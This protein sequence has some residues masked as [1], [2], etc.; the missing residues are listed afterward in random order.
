AHPDVFNI[1]LQIF[2]DGRLTDS[3]GHTVSFKNTIIIMTSNIGSSLL[4]EGIGL[5]GHI[6]EETRDQVMA[7]L[8]SSFRPEFLNRLDD[9][10]LFKPLTEDEIGGIVEL[11]LDDL[12]GRLAARDISLK[13]SEAVKTHIVDEGFDPVYG[14]RPLKRFIQHHFETQLARRLIDG[15]VS[16]GDTVRADLENGALRFQ[17]LEK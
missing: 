16:D 15:T 12:R 3:Q 2:D 9:T 4:L 13:V 6:T 10:V 11:L 5:Q 1:L 17:T 14:A 7:M 8:K